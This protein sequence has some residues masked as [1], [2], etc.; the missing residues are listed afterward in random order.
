MQNIHIDNEHL[1]IHKI[2]KERVAEMTLE[3]IQT[4]ERSEIENLVDK[5]EK[6]NVYSILNHNLV[7][8]KEDPNYFDYNFIENKSTL[9]SDLLNLRHF[10]Q[11]RESSTVWTK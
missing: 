3:Q 9:S 1:L 4:N 5:L 8:Q 6:Y 11:K 10:L 2:T 7:I